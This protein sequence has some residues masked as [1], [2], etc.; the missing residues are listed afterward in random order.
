MWDL[1]GEEMCDK[2]LKLDIFYQKQDITIIYA[3]VIKTEN[4]DKI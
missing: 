4:T 3:Q 1:S 2:Q